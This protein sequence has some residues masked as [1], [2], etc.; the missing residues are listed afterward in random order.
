MTQLHFDFIEAKML[1]LIQQV[2]DE[3]GIEGDAHIAIHN[4][5]VS[6]FPDGSV[7]NTSEGR[8]WLH[9]SPRCPYGL[10]I[11]SKTIEDGE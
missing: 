6:H 3:E 5:P 7:H 10:S 8:A 2:M 9:Y 11:Y 4:V 1:A